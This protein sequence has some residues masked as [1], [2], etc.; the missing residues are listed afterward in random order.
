M[1]QTLT[2]EFRDGILE[3]F[4]ALKAIGPPAA[5]S[6]VQDLALTDPPLRR[7]Y[8]GLRSKLPA[9]LNAV[10]PHARL[11]APDA[12]INALCALGH[13][14][15]E[16]REQIPELIQLLNHTDRQVRIYSALVVAGI[17]TDARPAIPVLLEQLGKAPDPGLSNCFSQAL[18]RIEGKHQT[19]PEK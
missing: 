9:S 4:R 5:R 2:G 7:C 3:T 17:G 16:A 8:T 10:L 1:D 14:G 15:R 18:A 11:R 6:L 13:M 19:G 12:R